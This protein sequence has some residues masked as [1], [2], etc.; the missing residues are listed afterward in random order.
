MMRL[1][2][3][4][5]ERRRRGLDGRAAADLS[6]RT[7]GHCPA[8][9]RRC[10]GF[11]KSSCLL[12]ELHSVRCLILEADPVFLQ[13][14]DNGARS[15]L[16]AQLGEDLPDIA[17]DRSSAQTKGVS[18]LLVAEPPGHQPEDLQLPVGENA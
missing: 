17:L 13:G 15:G 1:W 10:R 2:V 16:D 8:V 6:S 9:L 5:E 18:D 11:E 14:L 7:A 12:T 4:G 3:W